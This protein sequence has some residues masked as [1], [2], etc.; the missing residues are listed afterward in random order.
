MSYVGLSPN[1]LQVR[2]WSL[3]GSFT[4][5]RYEY[6]RACDHSRIF[7]LGLIDRRR[8]KP[9]GFHLR[10]LT[11]MPICNVSSHSLWFIIQRVICWIETYMSH[12]DLR[13]T[14]ASL[15]PPMTRNKSYDNVPQPHAAEYYSQR[16]THGGLACHF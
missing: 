13:A 15:L 12:F 10:I 2:T 7:A 1:E 4:W 5:K 3:G 16:T 9:E 8:L 11:A 14:S 6:F